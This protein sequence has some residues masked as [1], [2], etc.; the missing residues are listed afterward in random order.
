MSFEIKLKKILQLLLLFLIVIIF[1]VIGNY[2]SRGF[3]GYI[4]GGFTGLILVNTIFSILNYQK[5]GN[6]R[7]LSLILIIT[8]VL[9]LLLII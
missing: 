5:I 8:A 9:W 7:A 3:S 6:L 2:V 1:S 4:L